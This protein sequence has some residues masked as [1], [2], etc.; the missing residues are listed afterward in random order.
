MSEFKSLWLQSCLLTWKQKPLHGQFP[1]QIE[2]VPRVDCAY[3]WLRSTYLKLETEAFITSA[4]DQAIRT[5]A[6][7][8]KVLNCAEDPTCRLCH[9]SDETIYHLLS[10]CPAVVVT[11]YLKRHNSVASLIHK[12]I[13]ECYGIPTCEKPWLYNPQQV[14]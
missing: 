9:S 6:Y 4:Q 3:K 5:K 7:N 14:V 12:H 2:S 11:E 13:C 10:A 1:C 8:A